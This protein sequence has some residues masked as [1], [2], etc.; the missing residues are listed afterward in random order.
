VNPY[1]H[2]R[3]STLLSSGAPSDRTMFSVPTSTEKEKHTA[4]KG[5]LGRTVQRFATRR[6]K[7]RALRATRNASTKG[8]SKVTGP[9]TTAMSR[10]TPSLFNRFTAGAG[11]LASRAAGSHHWKAQTRRDSKRQTLIDAHTGRSLMQQSRADAQTAA[12]SRQREFGA[13]D[14]RSRRGDS[15]PTHMTGRR[16]LQYSRN[17]L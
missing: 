6:A 16:V 3:C 15:D 8:V 10:A 7:K 17:S 14:P 4:R 9:E 11:R 2:L 13:C 5:V 1:R 12:I